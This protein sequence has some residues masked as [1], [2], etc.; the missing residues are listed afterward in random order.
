MIWAVKL[1]GQDY[2]VTE[3]LPL[4]ITPDTKLFLCSEYDAMKYVIA[5]CKNNDGKL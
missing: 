5:I 3:V 4:D 2:Y 1:L